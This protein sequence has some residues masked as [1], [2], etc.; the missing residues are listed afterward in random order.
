M[1]SFREKLATWSERGSQAEN[2]ALKYQITHQ[3]DGNIAARGEIKPG[4]K[5]IISETSQRV[6]LFVRGFLS[7][8]HD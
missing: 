5:T 1:G 7:L 6:I 4:A 3:C 8:N 2:T